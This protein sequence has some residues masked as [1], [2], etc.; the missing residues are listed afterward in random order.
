LRDLIE[1]KPLLDHQR[2][3]TSF[4][5]FVAMFAGLWGSTFAE[6]ISQRR[7][8][9]TETLLVVLLGVATIR[10]SR[11]ILWW[12]PAVAWS[13]SVLAAA[14]WKWS[15]GL[16]ADDLLRQSHGWAVIAPGAIILMV[17]ALITPAGIDI[18][19]GRARPLAQVVSIQTPIGAADYLREQPPK[20]LTFCPME[21]GDYLTW[22]GPEKLRVVTNSHVHLV[23]NDIWRDYMSAIDGTADA[24]AILARHNVEVVVTDPSRQSAFVEMLQNSGTW[25]PTFRDDRSI[26]FEKRLGAD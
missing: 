15:G 21:W 20:G 16:F 5:V 26:I 13:I 8:L 25:N 7:I 19:S 14:R 2:Q 12:G 1:W 10:T 11:M 23:P 4:V 3:L 9:S 18:L 22:A 17:A 24:L 6:T